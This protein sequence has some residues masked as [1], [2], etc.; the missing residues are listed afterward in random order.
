MKTIYIL[1]NPNFEQD[2]LPLRLLPKLQSS[3]PNFQFIHLDPTENLPEESHL[4]LIDTVLGLKEVKT[5]SENDL[6]KIQSS[7]NYSLHDFDLSFSLKL[8]KKLNKIQKVTIIGVPSDYEENKAL[9][10]I[11]EIVNKISQVP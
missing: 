10:E 9:K 4:V 5:L 8:M 11:K 2:S 1:G 6:N 7:P 3:L